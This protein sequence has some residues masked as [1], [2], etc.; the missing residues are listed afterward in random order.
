MQ[1]P[2]CRCIWMPNFIKFSLFRFKKVFWPFLVCFSFFSGLWGLFW[3]FQPFLD[4]LVFSA[5][6]SFLAFFSLF[7]LFWPF[8]L[9]SD[10]NKGPMQCPKCRCL[11]MPNFIEFSLFRFKR[12]FGLFQPFWPF[13]A[14]LAFFGHLVWSLTRCPCNFLGVDAFACQVS[15]RLVNWLGRESGDRHTDTFLYRYRLMYS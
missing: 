6:L 14:F 1:C 3:P 15:L 8:G 4:F 7:S 11:W 10:K 2:K 9:A 13:L 12:L 5:F